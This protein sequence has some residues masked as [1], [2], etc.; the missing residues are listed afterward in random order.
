MVIKPLFSAFCQSFFP[1]IILGKPLFKRKKTMSFAYQAF[2]QFY[3]NIIAKC[4]IV[5][6][7]II[8]SVFISDLFASAVISHI[9]SCCKKSYLGLEYVFILLFCNFCQTILEIDFICQQF[10]LQVLHLIEYLCSCDSCEYQTLHSN[11]P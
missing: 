6:L 3:V 9:N 2:V 8:I 11:C 10:R 1:H 4:M 7:V 5:F